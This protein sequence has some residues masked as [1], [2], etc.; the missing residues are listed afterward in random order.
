MFVRVFSLGFFSSCK[1][2]N[3]GFY[4]KERDVAPW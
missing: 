4:E 1:M 2:I 3:V